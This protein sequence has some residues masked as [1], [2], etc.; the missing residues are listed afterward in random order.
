MGLEDV[1]SFSEA[2]VEKE[3]PVDEKV[4]ETV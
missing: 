4:Q 1:G 3:S 2:V